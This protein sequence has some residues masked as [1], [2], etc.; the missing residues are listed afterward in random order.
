MQKATEKRRIVLEAALKTI[1]AAVRHLYQ[2][3]I[4]AAKARADVLAV[5]QAK[6]RMQKDWEAWTMPLTDALEALE[7]EPLIV[8]R[9]VGR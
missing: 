4:E 5:V 7:Q 1:A 2:E 3:E 8:M 6:A 9:E